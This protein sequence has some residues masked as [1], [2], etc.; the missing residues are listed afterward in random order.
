MVAC[1]A[2]AAA[3]YSLGDKWALYGPNLH[4]C[5]EENVATKNGLL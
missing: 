4:S 1:F 3:A 2:A 5:L